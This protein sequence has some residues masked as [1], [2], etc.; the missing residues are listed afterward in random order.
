MAKTDTLGNT[1]NN[2][3]FGLNSIS[4]ND[5]SESLKKQ[6]KFEIR[7]CCPAIIKKI[8][9]DN[10]TVTVQPVITERIVL[11]TQEEQEMQLP[12]IQ[13]VP[14]VYLST[15]GINNRSAI[16]LPL[17]IDDECLLFF[18]DTCIDAWW[19]SGG[20]QSQFEQR[21]HDLSDCFCLPCQ[22]SQIRKNEITKISDWKEPRPDLREVSDGIVI[23]KGNTKVILEDDNLELISGKIIFNG[24]PL[25][26]TNHYHT[27]TIGEGENAKTYTTSG[28]IIE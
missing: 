7:C 13:D 28:P 20:I 17:N 23:E 12:E 16:K 9:Y 1:T 4:D 19:Q 26:M 24:K 15:G 14:I 3:M 5:Q 21:R 8:N 6:I 22:M 11:G 25:T 18:S 27:I 10:M 2:S